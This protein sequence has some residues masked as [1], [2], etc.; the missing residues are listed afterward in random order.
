MCS[1]DFPQPLN[2][3]HEFNE[4]G[5]HIAHKPNEIIEFLFEGENSDE[6][7]W[8]YTLV[9]TYSVKNLKGEILTCKQR[10]QQEEPEVYIQCPPND[11][12]FGIE[13]VPKPIQE[14]NTFFEFGGNAGSMCLEDSEFWFS[15]EVIDSTGTDL[16]ITRYYEYFEMY[17]N[18][19]LIGNTCEHSIIVKDSTPTKVNLNIINDKIKIYPNPTRGKLTISLD[20][21]FTKDI[22]ILIFNEKGMMVRNKK[23]QRWNIRNDIEFDI[24]ELPKGIYFIK[25]INDDKSVMEKIIYQ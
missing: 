6:N 25:I 8:L 24:S 7:I 18:N 16:K 19:T 2:S 22:D 1:F 20:D 4:N 14:L 12:V 3:V 5:G 23:N 11:V 9:R 17:G 10:I 21:T 15:Q 13:N